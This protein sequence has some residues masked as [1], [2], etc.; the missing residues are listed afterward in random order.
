MIRQ[1]PRS[2][3]FPYTTLFRS[4]RFAD[5]HVERDLLDSR[6]LHDRVEP[7]LFLE[8]RPDLALVLLLQAWRVRVRDGAHVRSISSPHFLHMRTRTFLSLMTFS[9]VPTRVGLP[10]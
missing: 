9:I 2:T 5:A 3:L 1:P 4:L 8:A 7:E 6:H 10:H